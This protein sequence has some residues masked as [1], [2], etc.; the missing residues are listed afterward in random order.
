MSRRHVVLGLITILAP[1]DF[2]AAAYLWTLWGQ[3]SVRAGGASASPGHR[4]G[5]DARPL[6]AVEGHAVAAP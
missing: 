4:S 5:G 3:R 2:T 1:G 6:N